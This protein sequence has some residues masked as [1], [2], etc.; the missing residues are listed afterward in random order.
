MQNGWLTG[1]QPSKACARGEAGV[2]RPSRHRRVF[3]PHRPLCPSTFQSAKAMHRRA[4]PC[5]TSST[6][7]APFRV[8]ANRP[9]PQRR[10]H[11]GSRLWLHRWRVHC[12]LQSALSE[13]PRGQ[14]GPPALDWRQARG[15]SCECD[16]EWA[17]V[18]QL[19][20][21]LTEVPRSQEGRWPSCMRWP[22]NHNRLFEGIC[23]GA[24]GDAVRGWQSHEKVA[25]KSARLEP[26]KHTAQPFP[27]LPSNSQ[28]VG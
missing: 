9:R 13:M 8:P 15:H 24:G 28:H 5:T 26:A 18:A 14:G 1:K 16:W 17:C 22:S 27:A 2:T 4:D 20:G 19:Q 25:R 23:R 11:K 7:L 12:E 3:A 6:H 21:A 10:R